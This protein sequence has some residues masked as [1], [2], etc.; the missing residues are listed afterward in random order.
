MLAAASLFFVAPFLSPA[1]DA[2]AFIAPA[3][4]AGAWIGRAIVA[5]MGLM[6]LYVEGWTWWHRIAHRPQDVAE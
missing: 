5:L 1:R 4:E 3:G 6:I 2:G